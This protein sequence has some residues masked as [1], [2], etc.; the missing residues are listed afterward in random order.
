MSPFSQQSSSVNQRDLVKTN[1]SEEG[2]LVQHWLPWQLLQRLKL[3]TPQHLGEH[4]LG[5]E[6]VRNM[7][8][9]QC[10]N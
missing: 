3:V 8:G 1:R 9:L 10:L 2:L 5:K 7:R 6:A 4:H